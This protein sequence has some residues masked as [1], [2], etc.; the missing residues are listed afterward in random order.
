[1][2]RRRAACHPA[3]TPRTRLAPAKS[4]RHRL[5]HNRLGI[6]PYDCNG[7]RFSIFCLAFLALSLLTAQQRE[8]IAKP[9]TPEQRA[10]REAQ[11]KKEAASAWDKWI[12]E[13]VAWIITDDEKRTFRQ[14]SNDEEREQFVEQC[15][16]RRDPTPDTVEN[17]YKE[18]H[19]RRIA[20]ANDHFA[21][22]IPGWRT[23]RGRAD[24]RFGPPDSIEAHPSGGSYECPASE[25]G[26]ETSIS[27][28]QWRY[29]HFDNVGE[30][31]VIEFVDTTMTGEYRMTVD[32][33]EKDALTY[34]PNAGLTLAEQLGLSTKPAR[35]Q[36][37]GGTHCGAPLGGKPES[38]NEFSRMERLAN[39]D[40][41]PAVK[42]ADLEAAVTSQVRFNVLPMLVRVDYLRLTDFSVLANITIQFDNRDLRF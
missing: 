23:D 35:F 39:F 36:N 25:G 2:C 41:P 24:I 22:G 27:V 8:T 11:S 16:L 6:S 5:R 33:C 7:L 20:W 34:V 1:M 32:P 28:E 14:L 17:E 15:W 9:L 19:Y 29:R 42:F 12:D 31:V 10:R 13:D 30:D 40:K 26:G 4:V 38:D 37:T 21:S 3:S 18:E